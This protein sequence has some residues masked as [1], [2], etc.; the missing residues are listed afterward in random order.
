MRI[1]PRAVIFD[2]GNV[3][4]QSQLSSEVEALAEI[5]GLPVSRFSEMYWRFRVSYDAA[6]LD[7]ATYWKTVAQASAHDVAPSQ[8][9]QLIEIDSRSW[10]HP[11][12]VVPQWARDIRRAGVRTALLSNMPQTVRQAVEQS[13]WLPDFDFRTYSCDLGVCKPAAEI[14][15]HCLN[16]LGVEPSEA[17]FLDDRA[18]NVRGAEVVGMHALLF[19]SLLEAGEEMEDRFELPVPLVVAARAAVTLPRGGAH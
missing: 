15:L 10:C 16:E 5:V 13:G 9:G 2:Y 12:P 17:L 11:A 1:H 7:P 6:E 14:Y 3:L 19:T 18:A 8:I 4:S